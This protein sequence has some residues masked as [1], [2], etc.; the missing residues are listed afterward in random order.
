M[1]TTFLLQTSTAV[2]VL[3]SFQ[4]DNSALNFNT[5]SK[6]TIRLPR[7]EQ[8]IVKTMRFSVAPKKQ[9][10]RRAAFDVDNFLLQASIAVKVLSSFQ[11]DNS[12]LNF[13]TVSKNTIRPPRFEQEIVK[14]MRFSVAPKKQ[15]NAT[16]GDL[17][18]QLFCCRQAPPS[19]QLSQNHETQKTEKNSRRFSAVQFQ[20][21][22]N[23]VGCVGIVS[24]S[25]KSKVNSKIITNKI[26]SMITNPTIIPAIAR[27]LL[28]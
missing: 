13:N 16:C 12:A 24:I 27:L 7:F 21:N 8:E 14:T 3:S 17:C 22:S 2:K 9:K 25:F 1:F 4:P 6:N 20:T 11:P 5:V 15:K 23:A 19:Q 26:I 28:F 18:L 10:K